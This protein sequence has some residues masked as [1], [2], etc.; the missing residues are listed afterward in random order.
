MEDLSP[1]AR[2][3]YD[4]LNASTKE[5]YEER[6]LAHKKEILDAVR[7]MVDS[8]KTQ[9]KDLDSAIGSVKDSM[10]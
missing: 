4:L 2:A 1:E 3:I 6:F 9:I 8:T 5:A 10:G 7:T